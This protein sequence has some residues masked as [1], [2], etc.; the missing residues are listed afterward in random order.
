MGT[1]VSPW[2]M[3]TSASPWLSGVFLSSVDWREGHS[4]DGRV[5]GGALNG[6]SAAGRVEGGQ[7]SGVSGVSLCV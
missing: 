5:E 6:V 7:L 2:L 1:S 4:V 3:G